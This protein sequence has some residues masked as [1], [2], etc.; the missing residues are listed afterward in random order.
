MIV[1]ICMHSPS[2]TP[3]TIRY[4]ESTQNDVNSFSRDNR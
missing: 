3:K 1:R 4:A 2:P